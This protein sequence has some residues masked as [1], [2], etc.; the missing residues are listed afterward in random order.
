LAGAIEEYAVLIEGHWIVVLDD[1]RTVHRMVEVEREVVAKDA[2]LPDPIDGRRWKIVHI[3][4]T[5]P[6]VRAVPISD[7]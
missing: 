7:E 4:E 1:G 2:I 5:V 6:F 3:S